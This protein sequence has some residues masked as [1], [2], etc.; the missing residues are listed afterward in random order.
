MTGF[1]LNPK[2][3][4]NILPPGYHFASMHFTSPAPPHFYPKGPT[5][6]TPESCYR[7]CKFW[8]GI[9]SSI[10]K[11]ILITGINGEIMTANQAAA[12][13]LG[14]PDLQGKNFSEFV[15]SEDLA[16]FF[17]N[18]MYLSRKGRSFEGEIML[19]R[20]DASRFIAHLVMQPHID[21]Q[22]Q[23]NVLFFCI[24]DIHN[25]KQIEQTLARD[26][27][28]DLIK[29]AD[30]IA[31][32]I[33]NP[34]VGIGGFA[35]RLYKACSSDTNSRLYFDYLMNDLRKIENLVRKVEFF[36]KLPKPVFA[37]TDLG[38]LLAGVL[39]TYRQRLNERKINISFDVDDVSLCIDKELIERAISIFIENALDAVPDG[40]SVGIGTDAVNE[41]RV[42]VRISDNGKGIDPGDLPYIFNPFF[43]TRPDGVGMDLA[44]VKR[45][46][47][48]HG[49]TVEVTSKKGEGTSF[50]L[51]LPVEKRRSIRA[52]L[53][54]EKQTVSLSR[55]ISY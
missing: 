47:E 50:S 32:E 30:G 44:I 51:L 36:A 27:Y 42:A 52:H 45:I 13:I 12:N 19:M 15:T 20:M 46:A 35:N 41:E 14:V 43:S 16:C 4:D 9:L 54:E 17:P 25:Q 3:M 24:G 22:S 48:S 18:L 49:G 29:V 26:Y 1:T 6:H 55:G 31:H 10:N 40:G 11:A 21:P 38:E 23:E 34:L 37:E 28:Q 39:Q 2:L 7:S 33:R 53:L 5:M 8:S